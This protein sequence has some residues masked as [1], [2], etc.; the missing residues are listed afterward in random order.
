MLLPDNSRK[1]EERKL[2]VHF[3]C[4]VCASRWLFNNEESLFESWYG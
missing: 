4:F 3:I 1:I 2:Y